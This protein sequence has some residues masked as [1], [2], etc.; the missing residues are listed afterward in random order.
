MSLRNLAPNSTCVPKGTGLSKVLWKESCCSGT[1]ICISQ[2]GT[3]FYFCV[4]WASSFL[5]SSWHLNPLFDSQSHQDWKRPLRSPSPS[6]AHAHMPTCPLTLSHSTTSPRGAAA[7]RSQDP[8]HYLSNPHIKPCLLNLGAN[9]LQ[10]KV[11]VAS[12]ATLSHSVARYFFETLQH[13]VPQPFALLN[14]LIG[15]EMNDLLSPGR[16][17]RIDMI[18]EEKLLLK[19]DLKNS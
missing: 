1:W 19:L 16:A 10:S 18:Q 14:S 3:R 17:G 11:N 8:L 4:P 2:S 9:I 12:K 7:I 5:S 13:C 6:S 15:A